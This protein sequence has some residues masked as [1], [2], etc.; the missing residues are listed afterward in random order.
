M[1][2]VGA[3]WHTRSAVYSI[4]RFWICC[5]YSRGTESHL[6][7]V[8]KLKCSN[9]IQPSSPDLKHRREA[10]LHEDVGPSRDKWMSFMSRMQPSEMS[11]NPC[12]VLWYTVI[13]KSE[14]SELAPLSCTAL[15]IHKVTYLYSNTWLFWRHSHYLEHAGSSPDLSQCF[16][17]VKIDSMVSSKEKQA[18][19]VCYFVCHFI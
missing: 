12:T 8:R 4:A 11:L 10:C 17:F 18:Q 2:R 3:K 19:E 1:L 14:P 6:T 5:I 13:A 7:V 16:K 9:K 15:K